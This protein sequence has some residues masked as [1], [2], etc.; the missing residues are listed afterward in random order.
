VKEHVVGHDGTDLRRGSGVRELVKPELVVRPA[1]ERQRQVG[2]VGEGIAQLAQVKA[3][4]VV[5]HVRHEHRDQTLAIG[6]HVDPCEAAFALARAPLAERE[7][8]AEPRVSGS[9]GRIDQERHAVG[10]IK[11]AADDQAH[12]GC[13][14]SF[15][16]A[17]DTGK[18]VAVDD[19]KRLDALD[20]CLCEE[21]VGRRRPAQEAEMRCDLKLDIAMSAHP[22]TPCKNQRCDPITASSPS[23]AR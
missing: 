23:P 9:V 19:R 12:A 5:G 14:R 2:A 3:T 16:C 11:A 13:L 1:S 8:P 17:N 15:V 22:N 20:R 4:I 6:D 7:Q 18:A 21:L 10:Q